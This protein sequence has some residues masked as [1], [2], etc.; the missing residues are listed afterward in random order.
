MFFA[1]HTSRILAHG[2]RHGHALSVFSSSRLIGKTALIT[3]ASSGIGAATAELFARAGANVVILARRQELLDKVKA[4]CE[5]AHASFG[6]SKA[7]VVAF[8][9]D[10]TDSKAIDGILDQTGG[11]PVDILVNN[12]GLVRGREHIGDIAPEDIDVMFQ[13][14]VI[15]LFHLTQIMVNDFKKRNAGF[16]VN[17]GSV[18]GIESYAGGSIYCATKHAVH[19]FGAALMRELVNTNIRVAEIMPGMVETEFSVV[20]YRGDKDRANNEYKGLTPLTGEDVAEQIVWVASRPEHVQI[21]QVLMFP[22]AQASATVN[23]RKPE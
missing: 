4:K 2:I 7:K 13:T 3:G 1:R 14:N 15:G 19:A 9:M 22:S 20:R 17:L 11:L 16:I 21:A 12:A 8:E 18:A 6:F 23:Y 5:E 10:M